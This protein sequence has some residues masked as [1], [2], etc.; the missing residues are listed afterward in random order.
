MGHDRDR[1]IGAV[2]GQPPP[3][4][5]AGHPLPTPIHERRVRITPPVDP[6]IRV[7]EDVAEHDRQPVDP[8]QLSLRQERIGHQGPLPER[9]PGRPARGHKGK[10]HGTSMAVNHG[11]AA[12]ASLSAHTA[13]ATS[14]P[15]KAM[16]LADIVTKR[17]DRFGLAALTLGSSQRRHLSAR[18]P[19]HQG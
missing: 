15:M 4:P 7:A 14:T 3:I 2:H 11:L 8:S 12:G 1:P 5:A 9:S 10:S 19:L 13:S 16:P 18:C 17:A 6:E